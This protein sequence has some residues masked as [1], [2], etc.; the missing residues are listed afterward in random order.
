M[1]LR[2]RPPYCHFTFEGLKFNRSINLMGYIWGNPLLRVF[3]TAPGNYR[4]FSASI[5]L[6][7]NIGSHCCGLF[8]IGDINT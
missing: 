8:V 3:K 7:L 5:I 6:S 2:T 1:H 4:A